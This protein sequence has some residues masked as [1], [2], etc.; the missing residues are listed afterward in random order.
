VPGSGTVVAAVTSID[1]PAT[2]ASSDDAISKPRSGYEYVSPC[3]FPDEDIERT[4]T[5]FQT[6]ERKCT[7]YETVGLK[8]DKVLIEVERE[9]KDVYATS[10]IK[11]I[12]QRISKAEYVQ[13]RET[14]AIGA[15][16]KTLK[17]EK[18]IVKEDIQIIAGQNVITQTRYHQV[19]ADTCK[20]I[21]TTRPKYALFV[22]F[23]GGLRTKQY[24][25][26]LKHMQY[27]RRIQKSLIHIQL[28]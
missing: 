14:A 5:K 21:T 27:P 22:I 18:R 28:K 6:G 25:L 7:Q 20:N 2:S 4:D 23:S 8:I 19:N 10:K 12:L 3:Q 16:L 15:E 9:L 26:L 13:A 11:R 24:L 17:T 1:P